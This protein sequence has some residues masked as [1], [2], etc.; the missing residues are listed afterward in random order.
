M[1]RFFI[2]LGV[3]CIGAALVLSV[4]LPHLFR[5]KPVAPPPKPDVRITI[6]EGWDITDINGLLKQYNAEIPRTIP[7]PLRQQYA[8]LAAL[9]KNA[10]MEGYLFPDTY[11]VYPDQL[12]QALIQKQLDAFAKRALS[13]TEEATTQKRT[14]EDVVILASIVE[15][16][17]TAPADRAIVAGIFLNRL[18]AGIPL[19]S[20]ATVN[21]ITHAGHARLTAADLA[22]DS[23]YNT[24]AHTGLPPGPISNPGDAA[25]DA[26]LHPTKSDYYY[27]LTDS[28][29]RT[30][31]AKT[32]AEHQRNR[33]QVYGK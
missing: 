11:R 14:L 31:F 23:P 3:L 9:P 32:F 25:L 10:S 7:D 28:E 13:L 24:Y 30:Y 33:Q 12:P 16:E 19:Q 22:T 1:K 4:L 20:D 5:P 6:P 17:V 15:K 26:A 27:F 29:G 21:Y 8:F 2:V 18:R